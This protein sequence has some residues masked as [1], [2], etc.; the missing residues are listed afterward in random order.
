[1]IYYVYKI[2]H[3]QT[4][5]YYYGSRKCSDKY[6]SFEHFDLGIK[7]KTS[8]KYVHDLGFDNF[9]LYIITSFKSN[10]KDQAYWV[11]QQLIKEHINDR[12]LLN[13][14]YFD[15]TKH[16]R[17]CTRDKTLTFDHKKKISKA[18][19]GRPASELLKKNVK[20]RNIQ[21]KLDNIEKYNNN[22]NTCVICNLK[23]SYDMRNR[24]TCS[25]DCYKIR[26]SLYCPPSHLGKSK[27]ESHKLKISESNK[28]KHQSL[29]GIPKS[30]QHK[31]NMRRKHGPNPKLSEA[32][33]NAPK[34]ECK[35]CK[36][37]TDAPN[38]KRWH[39]DNCK[40]FCNNI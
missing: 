6:S 14:N 2:I 21:T 30:D 12:L 4:S 22:P 11:E 26:M 20:E 39:G 3:K 1:M 10:E 35:Y 36:K 9:D 33:K 40:L 19:K 29:T 27:S 38:F 31:L 28:G 17:F 7:Y 15:L 16:K 34:F 18:L 23:I 25:K 8:S 5:Q 24:K 13:R 37:F 32:R